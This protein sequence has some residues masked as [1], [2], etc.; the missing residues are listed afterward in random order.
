MI[1]DAE[2]KDYVEGQDCR[3]SAWSE[4]ECGCD[5]DWTP[6]EVYELRYKLAKAEAR[7]ELIEKAAEGLVEALELIIMQDGTHT[8]KGGNVWMEDDIFCNVTDI[9]K[10]YTEAKEMQG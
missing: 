1:T 9:I 5:V 8:V 4:S 3:C 10:A 6:K 7:A 2:L